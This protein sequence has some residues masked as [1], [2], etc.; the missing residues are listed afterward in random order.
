MISQTHILFSIAAILIFFS[1]YSDAQQ[2]SVENVRFEQRTDGSLMVDIWYDVH[3]AGGLPL[4]VAVDASDDDGTSWSLP[5]ISLTG[6]VGDS[7]LAGEDKHVVWDFFADN[8]DTSGTGYRIRVIAECM[9]C[10]QTLTENYT[11]IRDLECDNI[12]G[13]AI[14][15]GASG[16]TLDLGGHKVKWDMIKNGYSEGVIIEGQD[17]VLIRNGTLEGFGSGIASRSTNHLVIDNISVKNMDIEDPAI[18]INGV[19]FSHCHDLS[20][21][22]SQFEF[23]Y[24]F[25]RTAINAA[26]SDFHVDSVEII[27]GG[28]AVGLS[29]DPRPDLYKTT[30]SVTNSKFYN[31]V[32]GILATCNDSFL[33]ANNYFL[34]SG[35]NSDPRHVGDVRW[36][37][38]DNNEYLNGNNGIFFKGGSESVISNNT[39]LNGHIGIFLDDSQ[40]C[41]PGAAS[42]CFTTTGILVSNNVV[43]GNNID[44]RHH[45][46]CTG[47]TW[48][49]NTYESALGNEIYNNEPS[50][51]HAG[52]ASVDSMAKSIASDAVFLEVGGGH[53]DTLGRTYNWVYYYEFVSQQEVHEFWYQDGRAI[54]RGLLN[55]PSYQNGNPIQDAW[56]D[57]D[58]AIVIAELN[59]GKA[60][61][62]AFELENIEMGLSWDSMPV[63][64]IG[65]MAA[66]TSVHFRI[67][68]LLE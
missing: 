2:P 44:L 48:I 63:W 17:H 68:A 39:I 4:N 20:I 12:S 56:I 50:T 55:D 30:G 65:Y 67:D 42:D 8:P 34:N 13:Y 15:I 61:R 38:I 5:C 10:G 27:G 24:E 18:F 37:T 64:G 31:N 36:L 23:L 1:M 43:Q 6:D 53:I 58:S 26:N 32:D 41:D 57:S 11:L 40:G 7:V 25:H 33:I 29:G 66:D 59:G 51:A 47:N 28:V 9:F 22:N 16:I 60:F 46:D 14:R 3:T 21:K 45:E 52:F 49:G 54:S 19:A 35:F 62:Q